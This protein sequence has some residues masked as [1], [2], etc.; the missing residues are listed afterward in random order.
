M[1]TIRKFND[2][3]DMGLKII[4]D[5]LARLTNSLRKTHVV[6]INL[7]FTKVE[8]VGKLSLNSINYST[9]FKVRECFNGL[10]TRP[11]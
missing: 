11:F 2:L 4:S 9:K 6:A 3:N 7:Q 8:A 1:F 10:F 5:S